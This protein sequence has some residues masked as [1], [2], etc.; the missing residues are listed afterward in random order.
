MNGAKKLPVFFHIPKNAGTYVY[1]VSYWTISKN[2]LNSKK[3]W[4]LEVFKDNNIAYRIICSPKA[5]EAESKYTKVDAGYWWRV[6]INDLDLND[7]DLYFIE[8]CDKSFASYKKEI[9]KNLD[10]QIKPCEFMVLR[11]P[12]DRMKSLYSYINS[13]QSSHE[14]TNRSLGDKSFIEYLNSDQLEGSWLIRNLLEVRNEI[15]IEQKH[16]DE[17]CEI[18]DN[19]DVININDLDFC[20][21]NFYLKCYGIEAENVKRD[22]FANKTKNKIET[23][24]RDLDKQTK[25]KFLEQTKWDNLLFQKYANKK[26][27]DENQKRGKIVNCFHDGSDS[28]F[29]DFLRGCIHLYNHCSSKH[30]DFDISL[31]KHNIKKFF[32]PIESSDSNFKVD[33]LALKSKFQGKQFI[34]TLK[35]NTDWAISTTGPKETKYIFSNYHPCLNDIKNTIKYLNSMPPINNR[36][37]SWLQEKLK[38]T[39]E[40]NDAVYS[41]L[42][43][44][45]LNP[46]KY[47][48]IHFRLGDQRSFGDHHDGLEDLYKD[49]LMKCL[50]KICKLDQ[51]IVVL[52]D[53]NGLKNFISQK[54]N[55]LPIHVL[56]LKSN[57]VQ[58]K[59]SSFS[60]EIKV[61]DDDLFHA[62]FDMKLI[63]LASSVESYSVYTHGSGFVYWIAKM[64]GTPIELKLIK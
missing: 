36:C 19:M 18:L 41:K 64:F 42:K 9:Y 59:P 51:P 3:P 21:N 8:V 63:T 44:E 20:L 52:S 17:V 54:N 47:N 11:S 4:S 34:H 45:N 15:P 61:N 50:E 39:E 57:H 30:I 2:L 5:S 1:N 56:H 27:I 28:G 35:T 62:V 58:K 60:G 13:S 25:A 12:Y 49:C 46:S 33:D 26:S 40:I 10:S 32:K 22:V 55:R 37:C 53:S 38:F 29:G 31:E 43:E 6:D 24:F 48:I 7:F 23:R 14:E 16:Y